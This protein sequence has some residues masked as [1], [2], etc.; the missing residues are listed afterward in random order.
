MNTTTYI[1]SDSY[2]ERVTDMVHVGLRE[3]QYPVV[4]AE[5]KHSFRTCSYAGKAG[6]FVS[7]V[8]NSTTDGLHS[9]II[10]HKPLALELTSRIPRLG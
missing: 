10:P 1:R 7:L 9:S 3:L 8:R 6:P 5:T 2:S 4:V